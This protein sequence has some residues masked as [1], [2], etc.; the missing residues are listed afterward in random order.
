MNDSYEFEV[1]CKNLIVDYVNDHFDKSDGAPPIDIRNVYVV[2]MC[3]TLKNSKALL[4]TTVPDGKYY[5]MTY[6]GEKDELY[7]DVYTKVQNI[8]VPSSE[9]KK[10][11]TMSDENCEI[12]CACEVE[13]EEELEYETI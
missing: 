11:V 5:E 1:I 4:S 10:T 9:F 2:W 6:N 8:C 7:M 12:P 13:D 3:K